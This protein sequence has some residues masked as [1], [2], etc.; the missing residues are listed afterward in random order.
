MLMGAVGTAG[1]KVYESGAK[2][3]CIQLPENIVP[4]NIKPKNSERISF[5]AL[6][7]TGTGDDEQHKVAKAVAKVCKKYGCDMVLMLGDNFY[8]DGLKSFMDFQFETKFERVY[9]Q[10]KKPFFAVLGNHDVKND[11]LSQVMHS[12]DS[13]TWRMPNFEYYFKSETARFFAI[14]TNCPFY[15][16]RLRKYIEKDDKFYLDNNKSIPWTISFGHHSVY[17]TGTHGDSDIFTRLFW[18]WILESRVDLFLSGHNHHLAHLQHGNLPTDYVI[19]GAGAKNYRLQSEQEK[20]NK[21]AAL[22]KYTH[23]DTGFV[24]FEISRTE[25]YTSFHDN[26]GN[27]IYEYERLKEMN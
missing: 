1:Y 4:I 15:Y 27:I 10:I 5:I 12:I 26:E 18:D 20:L 3:G 14:N 6:G 17:S 23:N 2:A 25:L 7:D 9:H 22:S 16:E 8:E 11:A 24:W 13:D 21:S 19:S